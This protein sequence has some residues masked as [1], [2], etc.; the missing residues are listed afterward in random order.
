MAPVSKLFL[1]SILL[2]ATSCG[3]VAGEEPTILT[4]DSTADP[5]EASTDL[6]AVSVEPTVV[7]AHPPTVP[8]GTFASIDALCREQELLVKDLIREANAQYGEEMAPVTAHCGDV[9]SELKR[10]SIELRAPFLEVRA[11][12]I[13]TGEAAETHLVVRTSA[14]W[15]AIQEASIRNWHQDPGCFSIERD[16]GFISVR[17]EGETIPILVVVTSTDRGARMEEEPRGA[18]EF[19]NTI[20]WADITHYASACHE[21]EG[22]EFTCDAKQAIRIERIPSTT[23]D[24]RKAKLLF[25]TTPFLNELGHLEVAPAPDTNYSA[26]L[27]KRAAAAI[28]P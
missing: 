19:V 24:G 13:E 27:N 28:K 11:I 25:A 4:A 1:S 23:K 15:T 22:G 12:G 5:T 2:V 8:T 14:G 16:S 7:V 6:A 3:G 18:C 10:T 9:S 26:D 17:T 20:F 21:S